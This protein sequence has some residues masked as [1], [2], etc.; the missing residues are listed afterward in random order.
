MQQSEAQGWAEC[1]SFPGMTLLKYLQLTIQSWESFSEKCLYLSKDFLV[2]YITQIFENSN[3]ISLLMEKSSLERASPGRDSAPS[4]LDEKTHFGN[5]THQ[6][7]V[8]EGGEA[9]AGV[10]EKIRN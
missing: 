7:H 8:E 2:L 10:K 5:D 1:A 3:R 6:G 9:M 4:C